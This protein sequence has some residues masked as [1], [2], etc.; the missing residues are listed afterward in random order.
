M[1]PMEG[2]GQVSAVGKLSQGFQLPSCPDLQP[3][4]SSLRISRFMT[5]Q[6]GDKR[7]TYSSVSPLGLAW[8]LASGCALSVLVD[9]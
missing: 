6:D 3:C 4:S 7:L 9:P 1:A 8:C 2:T 5:S